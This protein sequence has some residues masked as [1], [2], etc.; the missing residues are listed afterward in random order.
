MADENRRVEINHE[1]KTEEGRLIQF[2]NTFVYQEDGSKVPCTCAFVELD[3]GKVIEVHP[4]KIKFL[5]R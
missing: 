4:A 3:N 2:G 1:Y 5:D